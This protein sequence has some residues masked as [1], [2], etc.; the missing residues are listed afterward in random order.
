MLCE[1]Q[2]SFYYCLLIYLIFLILRLRSKHQFNQLD[3]RFKI[4]NSYS[5]ASINVNF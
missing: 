3:L 4:H 2:D 5:S 1:Q